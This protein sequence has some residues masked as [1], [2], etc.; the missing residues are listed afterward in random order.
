MTRCGRFS[1]FL[2]LLFAIQEV[3]C[4][5]DQALEDHLTKVNAYLGL[6]KLVVEPLVLVL[7]YLLVEQVSQLDLA[8]V[9]RRLLDHLALQPRYLLLLEHLELLRCLHLQLLVV[10]ELLVASFDGVDPLFDF[11]QKWN[12]QVN[13]LEDGAALVRQG[14]LLCAHPPIHFLL[15]HLEEALSVDGVDVDL[16]LQA[17]VLVRP[18]KRLADHAVGPEL[19]QALVHR[20]EDGLVQYVLALLRDRVRQS[21]DG[22]EGRV[23]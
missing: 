9:L 6:L 8:H 23:R 15:D 22:R 7:Y 5:L 19:R 3:D 14:A 16:G 18:R 21:R 13:V 10:R 11:G 1:A 12:V 17:A 20:V 4:L 2:W